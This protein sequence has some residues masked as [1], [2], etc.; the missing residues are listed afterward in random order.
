MEF[1]ELDM[2]GQPP[3]GRH[4]RFGMRRT[5][6]RLIAEHAAATH[7]D[8]GL[9]VRSAIVTFI[10]PAPGMSY[11]YLSTGKDSYAAGGWQ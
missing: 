7:V 1:S 10:P 2:I 11:I 8:V 4:Y 6:H 3:R 5:R 9:H